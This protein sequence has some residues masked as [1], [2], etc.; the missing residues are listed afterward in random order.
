MQKDSRNR[1][2]HHLP[3]TRAV[4]RAP[5]VNQHPLP[6]TRRDLSL[7]SRYEYK[8][9]LTLEQQRIVVRASTVLFTEHAAPTPEDFTHATTE[10]RSVLS[11][12]IYHLLPGKYTTTKLVFYCMLHY[13][14]RYGNLS[15]IQIPAQM[16]KFG[17][18]GNSLGQFFL[19]RPLQTDGRRFLV[20]QLA[21]MVS[22][23]C[24]Q[25]ELSNYRSV[26]RYRIK[27][28]LSTVIIIIQIMIIELVLSIATRGNVGRELRNV[29]CT[30]LVWLN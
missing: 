10:T 28:I 13:A 2:T 9:D 26:P 16:M 6:N 22:L 19:D 5:V 1:R 3:S 21:C 25:S 4:D 11:L 15:E 24:Y 12:R 8:M 27:L 18:A 17:L 20:G 30:C 14:N 29:I 23:D 7:A